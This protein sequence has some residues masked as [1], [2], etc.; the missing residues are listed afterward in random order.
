MCIR[1]SINTIDKVFEDPQVAHLGVVQ[2]VDTGDARG[3]LHVLGQPVSLA[4]TPSRVAA[5]PPERGAHTNEVLGEFGFSE[6]EIAS[7]RKA[8]VI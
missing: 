2:D 1:D 4:R 7:L 8:Q 6:A 5:P 3:M